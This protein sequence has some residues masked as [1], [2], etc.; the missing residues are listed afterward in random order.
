[1]KVKNK[2]Y[3]INALY[4]PPN[5]SAADHDLFLT[6]ADELLGKFNNY[7]STYKIIASDLNFGNIYCKS[8]TL[9]PKPLDIKASD[10]FSS[11]GFEQLIDIPT[12]VTEGTISLIDLIFVNQ[13]DDIICHGTLPQIADHDGVLVSFN[14][15]TEKQTIKTKPYMIIKMLT[16]KG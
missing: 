5:E 14:V 7:A 12:R 11:N 2:I 13:M 10:L 6:E 1:M 4:R 9:T 15:K 16:N 8:P 3:S